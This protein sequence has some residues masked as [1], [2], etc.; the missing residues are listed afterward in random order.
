VVGHTAL[1][2]D[3]TESLGCMRAARARPD[4]IGTAEAMHPWCPPYRQVRLPKASE[5]RRNDARPVRC[6]TPAPAGVLRGRSSVDAV[7]QWDGQAGL[8]PEWPTTV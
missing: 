8:V 5:A 2:L 6:S 7:A 3:A 4:T 1:F